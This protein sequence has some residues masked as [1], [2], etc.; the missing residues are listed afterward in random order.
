MTFVVYFNDQAFATIDCNEEQ[1]NLECGLNSDEDHH[2]HYDQ[3]NEYIDS[4]LINYQD[5]QLSDMF[6]DFI[7]SLY[8]LAYSH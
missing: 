6:D 8:P 5:Y 7:C 2:F 3:A 1:I 4:T